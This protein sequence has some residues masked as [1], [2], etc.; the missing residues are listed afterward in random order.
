MKTDSI[1]RVLCTL[2][3][4]LVDVVLDGHPDDPDH[5]ELLRSIKERDIRYWIGKK[6][7]F[8]EKYIRLMIAD[9]DEMD[10]EIQRIDIPWIKDILPSLLQSVQYGL[11]ISNKN[12]AATFPLFRPL[13]VHRQGNFKIHGLILSVITMKHMVQCFI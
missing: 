1:H 7:D 13:E 11:R 3:G 12:A 9:G 2:N 10:L 8:V 4:L 5:K 6:T